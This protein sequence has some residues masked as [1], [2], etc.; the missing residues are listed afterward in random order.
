MV[1][2]PDFRYEENQ[3]RLETYYYLGEVLQF[4]GFT[5]AD[6]RMMK[7]LMGSRR[8]KEIRRIARRVCE[9]FT[10]RGLRNLYATEYIRPSHL[11]VM[12]EDD[13]YGQ[14]M[15]EAR[16]LNL[17]EVLKEIAGALS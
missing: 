7:D 4:R 13:F 11:A 5:C 3:F 6:K 12:R 9:L 16:R 17:L 8:S 10:A 15:K 14:L 1:Q 2:D